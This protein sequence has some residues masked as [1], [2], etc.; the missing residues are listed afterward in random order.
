MKNRYRFIGLTFTLLTCQLAFANIPTPLKEIVYKVQTTET[1]YCD[2]FKKKQAENLYFLKLEL[3]ENSQTNNNEIFSTDCGDSLY[4]QAGELI[5]TIKIDSMRTEGENIN[6]DIVIFSVEKILNEEQENEKLRL[7]NAFNAQMQVPS[8]IQ[9]LQES[10]EALTH[11]IEQ[12]KI[13][14]DLEKQRKTAGPLK[15]PNGRHVTFTAAPPT[16]L[17]NAL[18]L[19][20]LSILSS[21]QNQDD[22]PTLQPH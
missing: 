14:S 19:I 4:N 7:I 17:S 20:I 21:E 22:T 15:N 12:R 5:K 1:L 2:G 11:L 13:Y 6:G 3:N 16:E 10:A 9:E 18:L 8:N